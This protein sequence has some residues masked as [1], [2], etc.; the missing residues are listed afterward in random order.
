MA[1]E[2]LTRK[3]SV[4]IPADLLNEAEERTGP[5]GLSAYVARALATQ[6]ELDRLDDYLTACEETNGP[7]TAEMRAKILADRAEADALIGF[8]G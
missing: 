7:V 5:R 8:E 3:K 2:T 6:L 1:A 4:T